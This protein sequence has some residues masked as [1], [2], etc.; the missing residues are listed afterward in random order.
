[1]RS[2]FVFK[3][4]DIPF[5][6][7]RS[8]L[9]GLHSKNNEMFSEIKDLPS[10]SDSI[11]ETIELK[12]VEKIEKVL[13]NP[14]NKEEHINTF[15][16]VVRVINIGT[17]D[18][19]KEKVYLIIFTK[20]SGIINKILSEI[21]INQLNRTMLTFDPDFIEFLNTSDP[22]A[23]EYKTVFDQD[24][25][26]VGRS[27]EDEKGHTISENYKDTGDRE[28]KITLALRKS[29][30]IFIAGTKTLDVN[31]T[32]TVYETGQITLLAYQDIKPELIVHIIRRLEK[33]Y[34][35]FKKIKKQI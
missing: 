31:S 11:K 30:K 35:E 4:N 32:I 19:E 1:M 29:A 14:I 25:S 27:G 34:I 18:S 17:E 3:I 20:N 8:K 7:V 5:K 24:M 16:R 22:G 15:F 28:E 26:S 21:N 13:V 6:S 33:A 23:N 2:F 12:Y 9:E 10:E